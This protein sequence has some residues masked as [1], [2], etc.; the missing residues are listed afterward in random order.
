MMKWFIY[1]ELKDVLKI[2]CIFNSLMNI[3]EC[4]I[5]GKLY[6]KLCY[7]VE[8]YYNDNHRKIISLQLLYNV[9]YI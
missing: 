3:T 4:W 9:K 7:K 8:W 1:N 2:I 5:D 6:I